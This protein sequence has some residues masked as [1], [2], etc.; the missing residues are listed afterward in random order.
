LKF[1]KANVR[2]RALLSAARKNFHLPSFL[3]VPGEALERE[4][5]D[6]SAMVNP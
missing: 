6:V 4:R 5:V 3:R 1:G 2:R